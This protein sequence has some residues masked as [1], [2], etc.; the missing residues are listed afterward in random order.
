MVVAGRSTKWTN[1]WS[2]ESI[3][4]LRLTLPTWSSFLESFRTS[5]GCRSGCISLIIDFRCR[6]G[7]GMRCNKL[8][9]NI[10]KPLSNIDNQ[11]TLYSAGA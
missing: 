11:L 8:P 2:L 1:K 6:S 3:Y 10:N 7:E 5:K 4:D 9:W